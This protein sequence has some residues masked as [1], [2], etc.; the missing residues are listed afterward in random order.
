MILLEALYQVRVITVFTVF[1]LLTDFVCLYGKSGICLVVSYSTFPFK[2]SR[3]PHTC[4][5]YTTKHIPLFPSK[6]HENLTNVGCIRPNIFH[7]SLQS[8]VRFSW[9]FEGK[10]GICLVVYNLHVWGSRDALK[11]KV[12]YVWS[13]T[14]Y[15]CEV[16]VM[17][18]RE[19]WNM[20]GRIQPTFV[21]FS[22]CFE[23]KSGIC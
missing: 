8:S 13:Y 4:R 1:R 21:R 11:G 5:L 10:S 17:L 18:W 20:F 14:T 2:A 19:K 9:C 22:W 7:F 16:L 12:E 3:E 15:I 6:H 23:G